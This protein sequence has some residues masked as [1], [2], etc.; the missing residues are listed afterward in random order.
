MLFHLL[1]ISFV[2]AVLHQLAITTPNLHDV[3]R[4][5]EPYT[6]RWVPS[7]GIQFVDFVLR[8]GDP[9]KLN[10]DGVIAHNVVNAGAFVWN[11]P[12]EIESKEYTIMIHQS[13]NPDTVNYSP[14]FNISGSG[15][16]AGSE[17]SNE[18]RN[19]PRSNSTS[20]EAPQ[21]TSSLSHHPT[22]TI[23]IHIDEHAD[24]A[25][26]LMSD[27]SGRNITPLTVVND[28]IRDNSGFS[29]ISISHMSNYTNQNS[30]SMKLKS[31]PFVFALCAF[32]S[33]MI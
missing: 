19:L 9:R 8:S 27:D 5:G 23:K 14:F 12:S 17:K 22:H 1:Q 4:S 16:L 7:E 32:S 18:I 3:V 24:F 6:I 10:T 26:S 28:N 25:E 29:T 20:V 30:A 15:K 21:T 2:A 13:A 31:C 11:V 33:M